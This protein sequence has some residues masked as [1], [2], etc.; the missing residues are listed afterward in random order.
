MPEPA[1]LPPRAPFPLHVFNT[2]SRSVERFEPL[3]AGQA[4]MYTCGPTVYAPQHIGN[5]R[6]QVF[7]DLLR[8]VLAAAGLDVVHVVNITDVGHL[9]D[10]ASEG[11]D[12]LEVAAARTGGT[13]AEIAARYTE[14]WWRDRTRLGCLEPTVLPKA[15]DHL[16]EQIAMIEQLEAAGLT[17][18]IDD[19]LYFDTSKFPRYADFARLPLDELET[20]GRVTNVGEKRH[21]ADFALWKLSPPDVRR[22]QEWASPW[23]VGFPG[24]HIE[25]SAMATKYLGPQFDLHTGGVDHIKVHHTNE[26]AQSECALGVHPWVRYW[27]HSEFLNLAGAKMS[28]SVGGAPVL[29]D[30]IDAGIDPTAFRWFL[31]QAHYRSQ[32]EFSDEGLQAAAVALR[33]VQDRFREARAEGGTPDVDRCEPHRARFWAAAGNDLNTP[34]ALA[35][36]AGVL[37][38]PD[39]SGADVAAL[40]LDFDDLL[41]L[42]FEGLPELGADEEP[43]SP[44]LAALV[45]AREAARAAKDWARADALR[46]ELAAAG[47]LVEDTPTGAKWR[48]A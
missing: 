36:V 31:L 20:T 7:P 40:L 47:I 46:D 2:A 22:Q 39:L 23:G 18:A 42:G 4:R 17:Y 26:I 13:A 15:T 21:P 29:D 9:T 34:Q 3:I 8:R 41:G 44:E 37:R 43:L 33:R 11:E 38:D 24:W 45:G 14:Q 27:L 35:V 1:R 25:C 28:K 12:K 30:I 48:R 10:D 32:Q 16:P 19:G 6:S 5:M